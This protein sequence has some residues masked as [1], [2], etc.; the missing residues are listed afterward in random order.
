MAENCWAT[1]SD[2]NQAANATR[3]F[4]STSTPSTV[5]PGGQFTLTYADSGDNSLSATS[6]TY[7]LAGEEN[8]VVKIDTPAQATVV[9]GPT[10]TQ[11]G[12]YYNPSNPS[13]QTPTASTVTLS[14]DANSPSGQIITLNM[15]TEIPGGDNFVT[16]TV[17]I[18]M[19]AS[20]S[21]T[22][23]TL[24]SGM[25][26]VQPV[27]SATSST[28]PGDSFVIVVTGTPVGTVNANTACWPFPTPP[29][30]FVTTGIID[31]VPP[32]IAIASPGNNGQEVVNSHVAANFSCFDNSPYGDGIQS[33]TATND[34]TP[35]ANGALINTTGLGSHTLTVTATNNSGYQSQ[36]TST[37]TVIEPPYD[38]LPPTITLTSPTNGEQVITGSNIAAAYSCADAGGSGLASCTGTVANGSALSTTAGY[39]TFTVTAKDNRGNPTTETVGYFARTTNSTQTISSADQALGYSSTFTNNDCSL[40]HTYYSVVID[41]IQTSHNCDYWGSDQPEVNWQVTAPAG[42]GGQLAVGDQ[43]TVKQQIYMPG[44]QA[45]SANGGYYTGPYASN[46]AIT[47]PSGT[48]INGP[49]TSSATGINTSTYGVGNATSA[50]ACNYGYNGTT[51][52]TQCVANS[53]NIATTTVGTLVSTTVGTQ[54][55]TTVSASS[56]GQTVTAL[57]GNILHVAAITNFPTTNGGRLNVA[58][59]AGTEV[60]S[61]ASTSTATGTCGS[62]APVACFTGVAVISGPGGTVSTGGAVARANS[63]GNLNGILPVAATTSLPSAGRVYVA[64][65][66]GTDTL[67]YTATAA[68]AAICGTTSGCLEGVT[69]ITGTAT[70]TVTTG[71]TVARANGLTDLNAVLPVAAT[72]NFTSPGLVTVAGSSGTIIASYTGTSTTAATCGTTAGCLTGVT[73][74]NGATGTISAGG[75]IAE[76]AAGTDLMNF[77]TVAAASNGVNV[78]SFQG[79]GTLSVNTLNTACPAAGTSGTPCFTAP[80]TLNVWTTNGVQSLTYTG[81]SGTSFTGVQVQN[82]GSGLINT[83][84]PVTQPI[85]W[86]IMGASNVNGVAVSGYNWSVPATNQTSFNVT[87]DDSSCENASGAGQTNESSGANV[88]ACTADPQEVF[89][90]DG[91]YMY[92]QYTVT[93]TNPGTVTV[94]GI[95]AGITSTVNNQANDGSLDTGTNWAAGPFVNSAVAAPGISFSA[96]DPNPPG[97]TLTTPVQGALY[98]FGQAV[99]ANY[100]CSEPSGGVTLTSCTGVEDAGTA[101]AQTV[102]N[103]APLNT[104]DLVPNQIHT[105]TVTA[106]N[107]E[108]YTSTQYATFI[109]LANPPTITNQTATVQS[110]QSVT[111]PLTYTGTYP[112]N[113]STEQ[114]VTPPAHGNVTFNPSTGA[115]TYTN[116]NS[117]NATDSFSFQVSDTA[118]NPSDVEIVNLNVQDQVNPTTSVVTPPPDNSGSY[119]FQSTVDANY[120][121]ADN[122]QVA[123]CTASQVVDGVPTNVPN[124]SPIDTTS[125]IVGNTHS[126]TVTATDWQGNT[127][128]QTVNYTV[129]T[130]GPTANDDTASTINPN[131]VNIPVL[132]NDTSN[133]PLD[134]S[135]VTVTSPATFGSTTVEPNG[136][137]KYTPTSASTTSITTDT[138]QYTVNDTDSQTSNPATVTVTIYPVPGITGINPTAGPLTAGNTVTITG[139]GFNTATAVDFGSVSVPFT[140]NSNTSIT[141]TAPAAPGN[142]PGS[143]DI[144]VT[145]SGGPSSASSAD[146]YTW[147]PV[148]TLTSLSPVQGVAGGG[149]T[150]TVNGTGFTSAGA[151]ATTVSVGGTPA[152]NVTVNSGTQLTATVPASAS[153]GVVDVTVSTPGG[154]TAISS[155]DHFTYFFTPPL[156]SSISPN[157]GSPAGGQS[158]TITGT[159][160]TGA[161]GVS[162]GST[163]AS[164]FTVNSNTQITAVAPPGAGGSKVDVTVTGPSGTSTTS[165]ADQFTYG[166]QVTSVSPGTGAVIGGT[167]VTINGGGLFDA[168]SVQFGSSPASFTILSSTQLSVI[169]PAGTGTVN[170]TVTTPEGTSPITATDTFTYTYPTPSV[171]AVSPSSGPV[172]GNQSVTISGHGLTGATAVSFGGSAGTGVV[173]NSDTSLTVTT[174]AHAAGTVDVTVTTPGGVSSTSS[175]DH[176]TFGPAVTSVAPGNGTTAGGTSVTITGTDF[177]GATAVAFGS[178]AAASFTVN[179]ATSITAVSPAGTGTVNITVT[180]PDGTSPVVVADQF[181]YQNPVPTVSSVSPANGAAIGGSSVII[182][183]TGFTGATAVKFGGTNA[184]SYAVNSSTQITAVSPTGTSGAT[185]DI[186]VTGPGGTSTTSNADHFTYGPTVSHISPPS[187]STVGGTSVTITGTGFTG[188]TGVSFGST[189]AASF[190]VNSATSITAVTPASSSNGIVNITVTTPGGTT[191]ITSADQFTY[192]YP[193]PSITAVS[194]NAGG[195]G[196]GTSVTITGTG[197][198]GATLVSFGSTPAASYTVN[199]NNSITAVSP[200]GT[201]TSAVNITVTGPGGTSAVTTAD[202]FTYGPVVQSVSPTSGTHLGG[203]TVTIKGAGFTGTTQVSFGTTVVTSGITVNAAGTQITV[204]APAHAAGAVD[205]TVTAGGFT[206]LTSTSDHFTYI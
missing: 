108:G 29:T 18:V 116:D 185:V 119:A 175:A 32:T 106:T 195:P 132:N 52:T 142:V 26:S 30:P 159:G 173:V 90:M 87:W 49:I 60:L 33:C 68:T 16:P 10:I 167:A 61:Y 19:K 176:Y 193:T 157:Q 9:S 206:S 126:L 161:T 114:V 37:Y 110:G 76:P 83:D 24:S 122:V 194:P 148:P 1:T 70:D 84:G 45:T 96:V 47:A 82:G 13:V 197:F 145:T 174:P 48:V 156:V 151:G 138:F 56:S 121:C 53:T 143:Q 100:S 94:P 74:Q 200:A 35:I 135:T 163:A 130:P 149:T 111:D 20:S 22:T 154:T 158:V 105:F 169:A 198:T 128:S 11:Q 140:V 51:G 89:G 23:N 99:N 196:G 72:A 192:V 3:D 80:G 59:S 172:G 190:T 144:T 164:S 58:T 155:A 202:T 78:N 75:A 42:N 7:T 181:T 160:F 12:Y 28:D 166:P 113:L 85:N 91:A 107:S 180:G 36:Q 31:N 43:L 39:H 21:P 183:G 63:I 64:T 177:S 179:S 66:A 134:P 139:T 165:S 88:S 17:S 2:G 188:A 95:S 133:F 150:I 15:P 92:V 40:G 81:I 120:S 104:T 127:S 137:I 146:V 205:V 69:Q 86:K 25:L 124:G 4:A 27:G 203:T 57:T 73:F 77:A 152:T 115:W 93:V 131:S 44:H 118:G 123:S 125:L 141:A 46:F 102:A 186:T 171:S 112:A 204:T 153:A 136:S 191:P 67:A 97:D 201:A 54:A 168:T 147:D 189:P 103:G 41:I 170:V 55:S 117:A 162:F 184:A 50:A 6:G 38:L 34:N 62:T 71:G 199:S 101:F 187:G 178:S 79:S 182:T 8:Q 129:N 109:T 65:S 14:S 98:S 5:L